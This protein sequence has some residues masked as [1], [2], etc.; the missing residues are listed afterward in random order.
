[1]VAGCNQISCKYWQR[2]VFSKSFNLYLAFLANHNVD[3]IF[4]GRIFPA[5]CF[6]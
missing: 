1:M 3:F 2:K 4:Y 6:V 5:A